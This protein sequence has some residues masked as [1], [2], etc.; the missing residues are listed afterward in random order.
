MDAGG[1]SGTAGRSNGTD[2]HLRIAPVTMGFRA[3]P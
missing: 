1:S 2:V 3:H